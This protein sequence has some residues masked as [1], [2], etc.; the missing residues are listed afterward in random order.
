MTDSNLETKLEQFNEQF[1]ELDIEE[2]ILFLFGK[3][4][5]KEVL[6]TSSFGAQSALLLHSVSRVRPNQI[7]H[8]I[9]T[10]F[11]FPETI[12]YKEKLTSLLKLQV[13]D[14]SPTPVVQQLTVQRRLW[15]TD[16]D[17]C[18]FFNKIA[19]MNTLKARYKIWVSGLRRHQTTNRDRLL[20]FGRA[21]GRDDI[22]KCYPLLDVDETQAAIYEQRFQLPPHPLLEQGFCSIGCRHCTVKGEGRK[23]RWAGSNKT[24]CGLH[25]EHPAQPAMV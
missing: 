11:H 17:A 2:R 3:W 13:V 25:L 23:G 24:E 18:C 7:I 20:F 9:D 14:I 22:I 16:P 5:E 8:F 19:V 4:N 15:E 10:G 6:V 21:G 1:S 12:E